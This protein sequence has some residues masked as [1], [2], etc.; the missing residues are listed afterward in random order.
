MQSWHGLSVVT[1]GHASHK[2]AANSHTQD[3][4]DTAISCSAGNQ[5]EK[6]YAR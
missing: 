3:K 2:P 1:H 6:L 4:A 5:K